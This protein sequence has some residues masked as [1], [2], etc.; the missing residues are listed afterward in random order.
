[1]SRGSTS[2]HAQIA[3]DLGFTVQFNARSSTSLT[4]HGLCT[5]QT[6]LATHDLHKIQTSLT[7][8]GLCRIEVRLTTYGLRGQRSNKWC[9]SEVNINY[10]SVIPL[11]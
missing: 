5:I 3:G 4:T 8:H 2:R 1:M 9:P 6:S 10:K 7:T 11:N